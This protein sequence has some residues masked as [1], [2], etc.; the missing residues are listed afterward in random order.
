MRAGLSSALRRYDGGVRFAGIGATGLAALVLTLSAGA[1]S[2]AAAI[3]NVQVGAYVLGNPGTAITPALPSP[4]T[5][6]NLLVAEI[7]TGANTS[8]T[9]P[10]GWAEAAS[11]YEPEDGTAQIWYYPDNPGGISSATFSLSA[12]DLVIAQ[13]SEWSG[14]ALVAPLDGT[15]VATTSGS[16]S[17]TATAT[18]AEAN[19][20]AISN[21]TG[22]V[23][24]ALSPGAGWTEFLSD[25]GSAV[26][27]DDEIGVGPGSVSETGT[28]S[29]SQTLAGAISTFFGG[30][31]GGSLSLAAPATSGLG[32][33]TLNGSTQSLTPTLVLTPADGTGSGAGWNLTG[34]STPFTNEQGQTLPV[35]ATTITAAVAAP[36][37]ATCRLPTNTISYP[38]TLPAAAVPPAGVKLYDAAAG[39]GLGPSTLTLTSKV[40]VPP[41]IY[42]GTYAASWF[43]TLSTGP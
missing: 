37:G 36:T 33:V 32:S 4:S 19:E 39:T 10:A 8:V 42:K 31:G 16:T 7:D 22:G 13:L 9:A 14:V 20:L 28:V 23:G 5:T 24:G 38:V 11:V 34:T 1:Q 3:A 18:A 43:F 35:T 6:G 30:C 21:F 40:A 25:P 29:S 27:G 2:A 17:L 41:S 26:W 12:S 15:G